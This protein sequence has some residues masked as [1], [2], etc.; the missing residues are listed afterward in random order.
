MSDD[1]DKL[2]PQELNALKRRIDQRLKSLDTAQADGALT[3]L[4]GKD[5]VDLV[6]IAVKRT[7]I[8]CR[9]LASGTPVTLRPQG[10]VRHEAEAH[11]LTVRPAR[12]WTFKRTTYLSG[13]ISQMRLDA[14]ALKLTPLQLKDEYPW[15]PAK[16][17]WAEDSE[18]IPGWFKPILA[19]G[20]RPS[21]EMEQILPGF[22]PNDIDDPDSD[23]VGQAVD[24]AEA[25]DFLEAEKVLQR[26]LEQD[27]RALDA[28]AHLGNI[29]FRD[30]SRRFCVERARR[31]YEAGVAIADLSLGPRFNGV[32]QWG[33]LD[34]RPF[35][36][37]LHGLAL[38]LWALGEFDSAREAFQR[39]LWLNPGDNQGA[40]ICLEEV[41]AR[42]EYEPDD[43][44][45]L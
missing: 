38:C 11:I 27:L 28:H 16:E 4:S 10:G 22:D 19:A 44:P 33:R 43:E 5:T 17:G 8:R 9:T 14:A 25:G 30:G 45:E 39:L 15:D 37:C 21:F 42:R 32:L 36:R 12:S 29:N 40:R 6:A 20:V 24:L 2:S 1:I 3:E 13:R 23:P 26:C 35:L 34:N 7:G 18:T 31:H 41:A